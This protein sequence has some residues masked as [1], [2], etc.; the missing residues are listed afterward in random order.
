[1]SSSEHMQSKFSSTEPKYLQELRE[2]GFA[3]IPDV[4]SHEELCE[5]EHMFR[6]WQT[7]IP[8]HNYLHNMIDPHGI[9]KYH[10]VGHQEHAWYI[11]TRTGVQDVFKKLWNTDE[12]ISSFDGSCYISKDCK[13]KDKCW[14][15]TD[16]AANNPN[17]DCYQAFV[18]LTHNKERTLVV[19]EGSHILHEKYFKDRGDESSK[20]WIL[21]DE[22]YL[23]E[24]ADRKRVLEIPAGGM[25]IWD[26]RVFHQ[27]QFGKPESEERIVQYVCFLPKNHK[28]NTKANQKKR[29]SYFEERRTTS[30][31]PCPVRVNAKTPQN[32]GNPRLT[33]DYT[34]LIKP[35]LAN[36]K[37]EIEKIL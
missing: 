20:N 3:I 26:S 24:I 2:N 36:L 18:A 1:M 8:D 17:L 35:N 21:I 33:I 37:Q 32:Y 12:L 19:Y 10:E 25:A 15:H 14:T 29:R 31:W 13:K 5:A 7:T 9:Y 28:K 30:H 22:S 27:N 4:I 34:K 23:A 11:R 16:Q 6:E